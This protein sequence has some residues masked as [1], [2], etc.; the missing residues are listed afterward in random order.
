MSRAARAVTSGLLAACFA[1]SPLFAQTNASLDVGLAR[2]WFPDDASSLTGPSLRAAVEHQSSDLLLRAAGTLLSADGSASG[3]ADAA[4]WWRSVLDRRFSWDAGGEGGALVG[5]AQRSSEYALASGRLLRAIG[6]GGGLWLR[7][8]GHLARREQGTLGGGSVDVGTWWR[9]PLGE[10]SASLRQESAQAQLFAGGDRRRPVGI[11]PVRYLQATV[12]ATSQASWGDLE[13]S[14]GAR[15]DPDADQRVEAVLSANALI[16]Q[17]ASRAF[18]LSLARLPADFVHGADAM[19]VVSLG[20]RFAARTRETRTTRA[21]RPTIELL[22]S[23]EAGRHRVSVR[24]PS[25]HR[26]EL[27]ADFTDWAIVSLSPQDGAY[28]I[29]LA[30]GP[31]S[32]RVAVR[33]DGGEWAPPANTPAIDDDLGGRVGLLVVP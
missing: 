6:P 9:A 20:M 15:R 14:A 31:G 26:V 29:E 12:A 19:R 2:V 33:I 27:M 25:A 11:A 21:T 7:A 5:D 32:H 16:W 28:V 30:I 23:T 22:A 8:T 1:G 24:A 13:L 18:T 4:A 10:L 3:S 17:S